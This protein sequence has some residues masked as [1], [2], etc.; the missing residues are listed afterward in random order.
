M[1]PGKAGTLKYERKNELWWVLFFLFFCSQKTITEQ[2]GMVKRGMCRCLP[3]VLINS[4][5]ELR[6]KFD[7][8][9]REIGTLV[10]G[11]T[12]HI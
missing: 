6:F 2:D 5:R 11:T 7:V 12:R 4:N 9:V 3:R 8:F 1:I 10:C